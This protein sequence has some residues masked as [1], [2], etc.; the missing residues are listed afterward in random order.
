MEHGRLVARR[1]AARPP[2]G[3]W[4]FR[5]RMRPNSSLGFAIV[6]SFAICST[7]TLISPLSAH[8]LLTHRQRQSL[9]CR[10]DVM[11]SAISD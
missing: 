1:L 3:T 8:P 4:H 5:A 2:V 7:R 9:S 11:Q 6:Y 10:D